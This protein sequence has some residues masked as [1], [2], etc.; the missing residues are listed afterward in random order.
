M[1]GTTLALAIL[2]LTASAAAAEVTADEAFDI[3]KGMAGTWESTPEG[4]GAEAEAEAEAAEAGEVTHEFEL[5]AAG[6]VVME[7]MAPGTR[8]EMI[9]MY[10]LDGDDLVL[11]HYCAGGNQPTMRLDRETSTAERMVFD[12][13][14]GTNLDPATDHFIHDM[15][16]AIVADGRV[17]SVWRSWG[18]GAPAATMTFHLARRD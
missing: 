5:S 2:L 12:F 4:S 15:E 7:T 3:L 6:T 9:N 18:D 14:G 1:R 10:H 13:T 16:L 17:E 8:H 11:T